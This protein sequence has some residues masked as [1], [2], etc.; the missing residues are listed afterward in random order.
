MGMIQS[1]KD[2]EGL[3]WL[4]VRVSSDNIAV[5]CGPVATPT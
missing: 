3:G 5:N 4:K 2:P 1:S